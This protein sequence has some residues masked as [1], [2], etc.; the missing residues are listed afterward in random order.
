LLGSI[1]AAMQVARVG[2]VPIRVENLRSF[3]E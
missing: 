3:L 1:S 2:N